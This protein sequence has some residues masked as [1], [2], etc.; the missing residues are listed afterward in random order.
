[1]CEINRRLLL[2]AGVLTLVLLFSTA[3]AMASRPTVLTFQAM[4]DEITAGGFV[5]LSGI[6]KDSSGS[7]LTAQPVLIEVSNDALTWKTLSIATTRLGNYSAVKTLTDPGYYYFRASYAGNIMYGASASPPALVVVTSPAGPGESTISL[8]VTPG[9]VDLGETLTFT[10][11]LANATSMEGLGGQ[12]IFLDY[13]TDGVSYSIL[14]LLTSDPDGNYT[15]SQAQY[16]P[17]EFWFRA[18]FEGNS[19]YSG[20]GSGIADATVN[21]TPEALATTLTITADPTSVVTGTPVKI[22]GKLTAT[23]SGMPIK[24]QL[25][26]LQ[27]SNNGVNWKPAGLFTTFADGNYTVYQSMVNPG[28]YYFRAEYQGS[29]GTYLPSGS[30]T[31]MVTVTGKTA[32]STMLTAEATPDSIDLGQQ[33]KI[34]G[35][36]TETS[37]GKGLSG[38]AVKVYYSTDGSEW[39]AAG[40][41]AARLGEYQVRHTP[42]TAG[43]YYYKAVFSGSVAY[44]PSE[45]PVVTV[46]VNGPPPPKATALTVTTDTSNPGIG[47]MIA[48]QVRLAEEE[49]GT[50]IG[51][52]TIHLRQSKDGVNYNSGWIFTTYANGNYTFLI[53][54]ADGGNYFF[55]A[56]FDGDSSYLASQSQP[57]QVVVKKQSA[58]TMDISPVVQEENGDYQVTGR[59]TEALTGNGIGGA[60]IDIERSADT[61]NWTEIGF[62][63]SLQ[64]GSYQFTGTADEAGTF[65]YRTE[66]EGSVPYTESVSNSIGVIVNPTFE[67]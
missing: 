12:P 32:K 51:G 60:E 33:V 40:L 25:I 34:S 39:K 31:V 27:V 3:P 49:S 43:T 26:F 9:S 7:G 53:S 5:E 11:T 50:G 67:E 54:L 17:G 65:Y 46:E 6:L 58:L 63:T 48:L 4:P 56:T 35:N 64:D 1:M 55:Q 16:A 18:R 23:A 37:G 57:L 14:T 44:S 20:S 62:A 42:S 45:S 52:R 30:G 19:M 36:L 24:D 22:T 13:S 61:T 38:L 15:F 2:L 10:G 66:F 8:E 28:T 21:G 47:Q 59:L 41:S 29:D